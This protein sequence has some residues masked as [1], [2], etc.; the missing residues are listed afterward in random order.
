MEMFA[1]QTSQTTAVSS[2]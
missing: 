1:S 2:V